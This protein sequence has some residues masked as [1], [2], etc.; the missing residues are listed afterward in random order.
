MQTHVFHLMKGLSLCANFT[1]AVAS[2]DLSSGAFRLGQK[3]R[4]VRT[5]S[6]NVDGSLALSP[7]LYTQ[8]LRLHRRHKFDLVHLHF[9]DPMS[10]LA[11]LAVPR[12]VPR[13]ITWHA[14]IMR[15]KTLLAGY[16]FMLRR[17]LA[18]AAA[19]I[20]P[21]PGHITSSRHLQRMKEDAR[22]RVIPFG[23][24]LTT[25]TIPHREVSRIS[26]SYPGRR[27]FALGRHVYYKGFHVLIEALVKLP[28]DVCLILGGD[29]PETVSL[30]KLAKELGV[31]GRVHFTG[32]IPQEMLP[33]FYQACELFC[34]PSV[35][36]A[37]AFGIVQVEAMACGKPIV[38]TRLKNGVEFVNNEGKTGLTVEPGNASALAEALLKLLNNPLLVEQMGRN[39]VHNAKHQFSLQA[40]RDT[41]WKLYKEI[42]C[43][44]R[45]KVNE[46]SLGS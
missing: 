37:E 19:V 2:R 17:A 5:S 25:F 44:E 6:W 24:D 13:V 43:L 7:G 41:T 1:H 23:F 35:S 40:M 28:R 9:P 10:H 42:L 15:H 3:I 32:F 27:I 20:A 46:V 4:G 18:G 8:S 29:G 36:K 34:L 11:S 26:Q 45:P 30:R 31:A 22:L 38:S 39:C 12:S 16:E 33:A 21:T 14:D